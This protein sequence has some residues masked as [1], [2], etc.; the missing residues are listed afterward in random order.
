L[1][2]LKESHWVQLD[3]STSVR[4]ALTEILDL[5]DIANFC[6]AC[7]YPP[8]EKTSNSDKPKSQLDFHHYARKPSNRK[9]RPNFYDLLMNLLSKSSP[10]SAT[11]EDV[12]SIDKKDVK[13]MP[14][15]NDIQDVLREII[16]SL[17][18][19]FEKEIILGKTH[20]MKYLIYLTL[21]LKILRTMQQGKDRGLSSVH[22]IS[23]LNRMIASDQNFTNI[24]DK[25]KLE[26]AFLL[27]ELALDV[28][29][30]RGHVHKF[31]DEGILA[32]LQTIFVNAMKEENP[33][34]VFI[35]NLE[36]TEKYGFSE[37][38]TEE[39]YK[40]FKGFFQQ[41]LLRISIDQRIEM[42]KNI[43]E[44]IETE[45]GYQKISNCFETLKFF[46]EID[47]ELRNKIEQGIS[48]I[49]NEQNKNA[50]KEMISNLRK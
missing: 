13:E 18:K 42:I 3:D 33:M 50:I 8:K 1:S 37:N 23:G 24:E 32:G 43:I 21:E 16:T 6:L 17:M 15:Q 40:V 31:D 35:K 49:K 9:N 38:I 27:S 30:N 28:Q 10:R 29:K 36:T 7:F 39:H 20:T 4:R 5:K 48:L 12:S 45:T 34:Q 19:K 41:T 14:N 22:V 25:E 2:G 11:I 46:L 44:K 26:I 47:S